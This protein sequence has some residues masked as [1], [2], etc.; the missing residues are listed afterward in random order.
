MPPW[1]LVSPSLVVHHVADRTALQRLHEL[2]GVRL[3]HLLQLVGEEQATFTTDDG[4]RKTSAVKARSGWVLL[5]KVQWLQ[6]ADTEELVPVG[7]DV[8]FF[9]KKIAS[10]RTDMEHFTASRL[11]LFLA[12]QL[13]NAGKRVELYAGR[14]KAAAA[15]GWLLAK[16]PPEDA[17]MRI[18][19]V[20]DGSP[21]AFPCSAAS[22]GA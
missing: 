7:G 3:D 12:G 16:D 10:Q 22:V 4:E 5:S 13:F 21:F 20:V 11:K 17:L 2:A 6:R 9:V 18:P 8:D 15:R 1:V 14:G 19:R